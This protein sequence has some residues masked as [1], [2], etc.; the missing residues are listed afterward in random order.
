MGKGARRELELGILENVDEHGRK[1][2]DKHKPGDEPPG[3]WPEMKGGFRV[4][5]G[6]GV[7][8]A[9]QRQEYD[10]KDWHSENL[11]HPRERYNN[12]EH[13][14]CRIRSSPVQIRYVN[15]WNGGCGGV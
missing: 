5:E 14:A 2:Q 7:K 4:R 3:F 15:D 9:V 6:I 8:S 10:Q 12:S 11:L 13:Q 1:D